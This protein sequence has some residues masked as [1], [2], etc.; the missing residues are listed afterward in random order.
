[1]L[2]GIWSKPERWKSLISGC[3]IGWPQIKKEIV[4]LKCCLIL[5][6]NNKPFPNWIVTCNKKWILYNNWQWPTQWYDWEEAPKHFPKPNLHTKRGSWSLFHDL[7]PLWS[8]IAFWIP[9]KPWHL[10]SMLSKSM[11]CTK[12]YNVC[13]QHWSTERAQFFSTI[14]KLTAHNQRFQS[15]TNWST[16]FCLIYHI[17]LTSPQLKH[18]DNFLQGNC[19]HN[20]QETENT[21]QEFVESWSADFYTTGVNKLISHWQMCIDWNVSC[22][23]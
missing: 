1:M 12:N 2:F 21:F 9:T 4:V 11:R 23:D 7:L 15:W 19:F 13:S 8:T 18:L 10:R 14:P 22:F 17:H 5:C 6:N 3:L 20:Q 16:K